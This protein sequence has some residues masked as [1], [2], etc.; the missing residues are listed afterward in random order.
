MLNCKKNKE[1]FRVAKFLEW[2]CPEY[3]DVCALIL[4][5][6]EVPSLYEVYSRVHR[7]SINFN[8]V[9]LSDKFVVASFGIGESFRYRGGR[10][11]H[12]GHDN[13]PHRGREHG[14]LKKYTHWGVTNHTIDTNILGVVWK[15]ITNQVNIYEDKTNHNS[16]AESPNEKTITLTED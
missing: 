4:T 6:S 1:N 15:V 3:E 9:A 11:F 10:N 2:L 12:G 14:T 5:S 16:V 13:F 8:F 7:I